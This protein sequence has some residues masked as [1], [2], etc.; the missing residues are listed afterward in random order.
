MPNNRDLKHM[1]I[2]LIKL[3]GMSS[4]ELVQ[5]DPIDDKKAYTV[6]SRSFGQ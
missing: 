1:K 3:S 6:V 2:K 5:I 4:G